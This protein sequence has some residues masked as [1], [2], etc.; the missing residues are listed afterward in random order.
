VLLG[1]LALFERDERRNAAKAEARCNRRLLVDIDLGEAGLKLLGGTRSW[2]Y[3]LTREKG[4]Q[5]R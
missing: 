1:D 4:K 2:P 3:G 5:R